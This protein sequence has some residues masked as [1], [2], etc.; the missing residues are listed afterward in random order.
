MTAPVKPRDVL[1]LYRKLLRHGNLFHSFNY[2]LYAVRKVRDSFKEKKLL[3]DPPK[4]EQE[5]NQGLQS[6]Q[7]L[8][9]QTSISQMYTAPKLVVEE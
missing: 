1:S 2:R 3:T 6:L 7:M 9:R 8:K 5:Y 4:I